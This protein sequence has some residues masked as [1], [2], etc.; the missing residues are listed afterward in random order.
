MDSSPETWNDLFLKVYRDR[1]D[2]LFDFNNLSDVGTNPECKRIYA[3]LNFN[4]NPDLQDKFAHFKVAGDCDFNFND[5]KVK[6]FEKILGE[7]NND[8]LK[9]CHEHHH[10]FCNFS[11]MP[12]T[13]GL[14]NSKGTLKHE[15]E[16]CPLDR[17]DSFICELDKYYNG[18]DTAILNTVNKAA[19]C[20]W[21]SNFKDVY[22]YCHDVYF[23]S[24]KTFVDKLLAHGQK[25][26][27]NRENLISY[28]HLALEYWEIKHAE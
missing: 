18:Q 5:K 1:F 3:R 21:L 11:F 14:N 17:F 7:T 22:E 4:K 19:V 24:D 27:N 2:A 23:I 12:I 8:L 13:G 6:I 15:K 9:K 20:W 28:M 26:L 10:S 16:L 25:P